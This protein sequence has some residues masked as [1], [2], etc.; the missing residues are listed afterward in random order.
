MSEAARVIAPP[1]TAIAAFAE[2]Q[3]PELRDRI[4][5]EFN[6]LAVIF[7]EPSAA[8]TRRATTDELS[9]GLEQLVSWDHA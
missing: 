3:S 2:D 1:L 5:D 6:T 4:F 9:N 7:K 8:F